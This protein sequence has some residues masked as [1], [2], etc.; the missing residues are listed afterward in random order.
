MT[1]QE[2]IA[3]NEMVTMGELLY[4]RGYAFG[5]AGNIS[6]KLADGNILL[7]PTNSCLGQLNAATLSKLSQD[8]EP[9][10]GDKPTKEFPL[11]LAYYHANPQ[12]GAVVHLHSH[13]LTALAC[14]ATENATSCLPAITPYYVMRFSEL[15]LIP[16]CKPG[17]PALAEMIFEYARQYNALLLANHGPVVIGKDLRSA[18]FNAEELE[19]TARLYFTLKGENYHPL[20]NQDIWQLKQQ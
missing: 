18:V 19:A 15:P 8:G 2:H 3:R 9:L 10:G 16:Y 6:V 13:F 17:D 1:Q 11:H 5:G 12:C 7:S 4:Q 14:L 20:S